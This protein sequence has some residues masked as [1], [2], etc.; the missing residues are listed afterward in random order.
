MP[1]START[2]E[3][4]RSA[5]AADRDVPGGRAA[6]AVDGLEDLG[7]AGA[8]QPGEPDDLAGAHRER[9]VLE[10]AAKAEP[11]DLEHDRGVGRQLAPRRED[12]RRRGRS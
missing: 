10:D 5:L 2:T 3:P 11:L 1:A 9:D 12:V 6:R 4:R 8:D 7:A